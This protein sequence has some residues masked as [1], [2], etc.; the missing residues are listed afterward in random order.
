MVLFLIENHATFETVMKPLDCD[1][2][3]I[4]LRRKPIFF[5]LSVPRN[6]M[7]DA[8]RQI[9]PKLRPI[10]HCII[11]HFGPKGHWVDCQFCPSR[12]LEIGMLTVRESSNAYRETKEG[13]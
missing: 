8:L 12:Q 4:P 7:R 11:V 13:G 3:D 9:L 2:F 6:E 10:F 5:T 1:H